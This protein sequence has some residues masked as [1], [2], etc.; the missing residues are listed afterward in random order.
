MFLFIFSLA[1]NSLVHCV[2]VSTNA[3]CKSMTF[4]LHSFIFD[5]DVSKW[6]FVQYLDAWMFNIQKPK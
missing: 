6:D 2:V 1:T 4:N 5:I 3:A